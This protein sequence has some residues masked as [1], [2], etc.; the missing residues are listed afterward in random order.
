MPITVV[1]SI[2]FYHNNVSVSYN[3]SLK[4]S[5]VADEYI[6]KIIDS[7]S[8][9]PSFDVANFTWNLEYSQN[10]FKYYPCI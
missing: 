7:N 4:N 2:I 3:H 8:H 1:A 9:F 5:Q 6:S 10:N